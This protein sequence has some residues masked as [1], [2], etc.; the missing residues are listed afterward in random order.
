MNY[1]L[2]YVNGLSKSLRHGCRVSFSLR[3][4][5]SGAMRQSIASASTH[6]LPTLS[7]FWHAADLQL[8]Q[9]LGLFAKRN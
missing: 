3:I 8:R 5:S 6:D 1:E 7:G 4:I 9:Q 2:G